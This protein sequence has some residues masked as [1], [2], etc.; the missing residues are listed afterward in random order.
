PFL[1][2]EEV[3]YQA[4]ADFP[5]RGRRQEVVR[6]RQTFEGVTDR[7]QTNAED[8]QQV[9]ECL[10]RAGRGIGEGLEEARDVLAEV[11]QFERQLVQ[12]RPCGGDS[13]LQAGHGV[14]GHAAQPEREFLDRW[15]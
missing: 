15:G 14:L 3:P 12:Y 11:R 5:Q 6:L 4:L 7:A 8:V 1:D 2:S 9:T 10:R 13:L